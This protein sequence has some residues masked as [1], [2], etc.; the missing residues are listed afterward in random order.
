MDPIRA[1]HDHGGREGVRLDPARRAAARIGGPCSRWPAVST[2]MLGMSL[3]LAATRAPAQA[4]AVG[5]GLRVWNSAWHQDP[6]VEVAAGGG[7]TVARRSNGS[8]VVWGWNNYEQCNVPALPSG[9]SYVEVAAGFVHSVARRSDGSVVAWG[10]GTF[11]QLSVPALPPGLAYVE[12]AAGTAH[13]VARRSDGSVVAWG[14]NSV[15]QCTVP[16][17]P[18]GLSYVEVA[19]GGFHTVARRSDGS[20]VAWGDNSVVSAT[21]PRC[22]RD[23]PTS[24]SRRVF[25][26]RRAPQRRLGRGLGNNSVGQCNVPALPPGLTYVEVAAG[27]GTPSRAAATARSWP[28]GELLRPVQCASAA[29]RTQLRRSGSRWSVLEFLPSGHTVARRSD[30]LVVAWGDNTYGECNVPALPPGLAYVEVA[31]GGDILEPT[32]RTPQRWLGR[33]LGQL[34]LRPVQ[35]ASTAARTHLRRGRSGCLAERRAPQRRFGR[36]L[37]LYTGT[38]PVLP[39]GLAYVA[40]AAGIRTP[41]RAAATVRSWPGA[42]T[43]T[44]SAACPHCQQDSATSKLRRVVAHRRAPQRWLGRG[45]GSEQLRPVQRARTAARTHLRRRRSG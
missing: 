12:V 34:R 10:R 6:F 23:S 30:G 2:V 36:G 38:V 9:L 43:A 40:V 45:L 31:A 19:A 17:L 8:V 32:R 26:H 11:G 22:R 25:A 29:V 4:Q 16:A 37:G 14:D 24:R 33:G 44:A 20:V 41:S 28:G 35:R 27:I 3:L 21:C 18:P 7:H 13:S 42:T 39:P 15:G 5:W 1:L